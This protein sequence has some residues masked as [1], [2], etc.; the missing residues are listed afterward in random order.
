ML[1]EGLDNTNVTLIEPARYPEQGMGLDYVA[2][3]LGVNLNDYEQRYNK[4]KIGNWIDTNYIGV[5]YDDDYED[6]D[7]RF[8][9][10][11]HPDIELKNKERSICLYLL[12]KETSH[13]E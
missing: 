5:V 9:V 7:V 6:E 13:I 1:I 8:A 10:G 3:Q 4:V 11:N 12:G 2:K